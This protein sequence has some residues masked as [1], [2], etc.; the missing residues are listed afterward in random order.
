MLSILFIILIL[1]LVVVFIL[2]IPV[3]IYKS[4]TTKKSNCPKCENAVKLIGTPVKCPMCK[5]KLYKH[6][7]GTYKIQD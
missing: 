4:A 6:G 2:A 7:D 1:F 5:T 3:A